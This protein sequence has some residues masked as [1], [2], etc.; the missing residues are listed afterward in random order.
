M[1]TTYF[2]GSLLIKTLCH[3]METKRKHNEIESASEQEQEPPSDREIASPKGHDS[4]FALGTP[5]ASSG[6]NWEM[7]Q[8]KK[9][10]RRKKNKLKVGCP[11]NRLG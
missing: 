11:C 7:A 4:H 9:S 10:K 3:N 2:Q 5:Q 6:D 1:S 8:S